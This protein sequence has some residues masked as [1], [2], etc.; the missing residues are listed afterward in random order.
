MV[1]IKRFLFALCLVI[2]GGC[3]THLPPGNPDYN[4]LNGKWFAVRGSSGW[5]T[6]L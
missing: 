1:L 3:S 2:L 6:E 5:T 4:W